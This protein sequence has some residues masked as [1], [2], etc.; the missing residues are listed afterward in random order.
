MTL[1]E[2]CRTASPAARCNRGRDSSMSTLWS[3]QVL[4]EEVHEW[5]HIRTS[6]RVRARRS[7]VC[8]SAQGVRGKQCVKA[9]VALAGKPTTRRGGLSI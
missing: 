5:V 7:K 3:M 1:W 9:A 2:A 4:E 8:N 6:F